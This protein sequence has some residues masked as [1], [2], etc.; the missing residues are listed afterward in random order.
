MSATLASVPDYCDHFARS[1]FGLAV[2]LLT[3]NTSYRK[4]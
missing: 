1:T 4:R 3:G 2:E